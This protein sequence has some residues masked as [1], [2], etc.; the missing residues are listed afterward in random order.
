M[1]ER[2]NR[3]RAAKNPGGMQCQKCDEIFIGEEWHILCGV[4]VKLRDPSQPRDHVGS[5]AQREGS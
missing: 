5:P 2:L 3:D 1:T 4:C